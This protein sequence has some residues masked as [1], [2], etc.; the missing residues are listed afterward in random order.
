MRT[1]ETRARQWDLARQYEAAWYRY[2][3]II[4]ETF[5]TDEELKK[6]IKQPFDTNNQH[7]GWILEQLLP[8]IWEG[9]NEEWNKYWKINKKKKRKKKQGEPPQRLKKKRLKTRST[10][11]W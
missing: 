4:W 3:E 11:Y 8:G 5:K 1:L 9:K 2:R 10:E 7:M 6:L